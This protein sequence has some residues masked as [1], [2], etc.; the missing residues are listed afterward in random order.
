MLYE[1]KSWRH[2]KILF[3][4]ESDC[5]KSCV[6]IAIKQKINLSGADLLG[7]DLLG[8]DLLGANLSGANLFGA[9]LLKANLSGA[10][11]SGANLSG[12]DLLGANLLGANLSGA[13]LSGANLLGADLLRANLLGA[14]LSGADLSGAKGINKFLT[15]P[16]TILLEQ[17]SKIRAYKLVNENMEGPFKGGIKYKIGKPYEVLDTNVDDTVECS[18]GIN[19]ASL[20]WCLKNY[21]IGYHILIAEF[22]AKDIACIPIGSDGKFRVFRCTI[23]GEKNLKEIGIE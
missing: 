9:D 16:M 3:S 1:I 7:A 2:G 6:E 20:D 19:L 13:N 18:T 8:A 21:A 10:D 22:E 17:P 15:T 5:L 11:L 12:V 4:A 23:V 14:N